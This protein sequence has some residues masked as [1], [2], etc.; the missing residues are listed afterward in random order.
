MDYHKFINLP[1]K[2]QGLGTIRYHLRKWLKKSTNVI[3]NL[4]KTVSGAEGFE[5]PNGGT[6]TRSLT[7]WPRPT[8]I[9]YSHFRKNERKSQ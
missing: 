4:F 2:M 1:Q 8:I 6:K 9:K 3:L 5:P 7:T